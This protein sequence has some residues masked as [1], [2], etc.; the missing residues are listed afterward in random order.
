MLTDLLK[1]FDLF[2]HDF[3]KSGS[4]LSEN[5]VLPASMKGL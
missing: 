5:L 4:H 1:A 3:W 2:N